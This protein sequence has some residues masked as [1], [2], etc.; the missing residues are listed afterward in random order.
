MLINNEFIHTK[1]YTV[2]NPKATIIL[3]HGIA[4]HH[5]KYKTL[6]DYLNQNNY[7]VIAYD[8]RGHGKSGGKRGYVK[9]VNLF[10]E[11]VSELV[12]YAK[13]RYKTKIFLIG[14]S[15]GSLIHNLYLVNYNDINVDGVIASG[16]AGNFTRNTRFLRFF[17]GEL[18]WFYKIKTKWDDPKL[19]SDPDQVANLK[20][21][22]YLLDYFYLSLINQTMI[23]G[24]RRIRKNITQIDCPYLFIH[25]EDDQIVPPELS[26]FLYEDIKSS[27]KTRNVYPGF[28]HNT[29]NDDN[30]EI[31]FNDIISWLDKRV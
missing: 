17:P 31:I 13:K 1:N 16:A 26:Q 19:Y 18:L 4:E 28:K 11:D 5:M 15:M 12:L 9:S 29:L 2:E 30:S 7:N 23:K 3:S 6:I 8:L 10:A 25:G 14:H 21:D 22:D 27:D 20:K 24:M